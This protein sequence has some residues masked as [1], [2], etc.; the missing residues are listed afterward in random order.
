MTIQTNDGYRVG[1]GP[2]EPVYIVNQSLGSSQDGGPSWT[3]SI[4]V[5]GAAFTSANQSASA[6]AVT[7]APT[8]GKALVVT[9]LFVS[10]DTALT[11]TFT[12]ESSNTV[13]LK[14]YL[15]ANFAGQI[16]TPRGKFKL[17]DVNRRLFVQ[18]SASGNIAVTAVYH[19]E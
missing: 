17:S 14:A 8:P 5:N 1:G 12:E 11:M 10:T 9:D 6:A 2:A 19:S 7:D 4:G 13:K 16:W 18:T 3:D 15:P